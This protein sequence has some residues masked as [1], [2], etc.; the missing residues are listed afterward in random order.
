MIPDES[1]V[2]QLVA[3][4]ED[5]RIRHYKLDEREPLRDIK[6]KDWNSVFEKVR[7]YQ[8]KIIVF[9]DNRARERESTRY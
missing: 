6:S 4:L 1:E 3:W 5:M 2:R 8:C 7:E 9:I